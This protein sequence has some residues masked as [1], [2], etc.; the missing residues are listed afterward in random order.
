MLVCV[1]L[2]SV[3]LPPGRP[4]AADS[5]CGNKKKHLW[6][7]RVYR[8]HT[9]LYSEFFSDAAI[10]LNEHVLAPRLSCCLITSDQFKKNYEPLTY[11]FMPCFISLL[12]P[13][14]CVVSVSRRVS[15]LTCEMPMYFTFFC[16]LSNN[17]RNIL[18]LYFSFFCFLSN[19]NLN[20]LLGH[21]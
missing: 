2:R 15:Y 16:F 8:G 12:S 11:F 20:R 9:H 18:L 3:S 6:N 19:N 7:C 14:S 17:D 5:R 10:K 21:R 4:L 13:V 1:R